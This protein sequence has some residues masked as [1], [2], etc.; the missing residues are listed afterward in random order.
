MPLPVSFAGSTPLQFMRR[1]VLRKTNGIF[2]YTAS[3]VLLVF[4]I[5]GYA[6]LQKSAQHSAEAVPRSS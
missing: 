3:A 1:D 4:E 2:P 5:A 6:A